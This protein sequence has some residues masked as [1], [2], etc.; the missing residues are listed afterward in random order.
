MA[1]RC[2]I[3]NRASSAHKNTVIK[4]KNLEA[5]PGEGGYWYNCDNA[6]FKENTKVVVMHGNPYIINPDGTV[7]TYADTCI[8]IKTWKNDDEEESP[9]DI[10]L[11]AFGIENNNEIDMDFFIGKKFEVYIAEG[12]TREGGRYWQGVDFAI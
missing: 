3:S 8:T 1:V 2:K 11:D 6:Y 5:F 4:H 9:Y 10:L 12:I 7:I